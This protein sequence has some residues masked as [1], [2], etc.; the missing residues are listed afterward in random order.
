[1]SIFSDC[2]RGDT[3]TRLPFGALT[4]VTIG[5]ETK[6]IR[7]L[8]KD[9]MRDFL[10]SEEDRVVA[11]LESLGATAES[12]DG[13]GVT[14]DTRDQQWDVLTN[15]TDPVE[16]LTEATEARAAGKAEPKVSAENILKVWIVTGKHLYRL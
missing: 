14:G 11:L 7:D 9:E 6:Q 2:F 4:E 8:S 15:T 3:A 10:K 5:D 13:I 1:M 16:E 12:I